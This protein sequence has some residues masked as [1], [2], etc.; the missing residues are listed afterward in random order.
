MELI[1]SDSLYDTPEWEEGKFARQ[2]ASN[3]RHID[4][5]LSV[6]EANIGHGADWPVCVVELL[7]DVNWSTYLSIAGFSSLFLMGDKINKNIVAWIEIVKKIS[8]LLKKIKPTRIDE[9]AALVFACDDYIKTYKQ[10]TDFNITAQIIP[11]S[12]F[13]DNKN[14]LAKRPDALYVIN[15]QTI[16]EIIVYGIKSNKTIEFKHKINT[17]GY[18]V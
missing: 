10:K 11:F 9:Y 2:I 3:M 18:G 4:P 5:K 16:N 8:E 15:I 17:N 1:F 6:T 7:K 12:F 14:N 13:P